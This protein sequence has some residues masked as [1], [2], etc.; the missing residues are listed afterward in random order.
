M[1]KKKTPMDWTGWV[2]YSPEV[3]SYFTSIQHAAHSLCRIRLNRRTVPI[4]A[5]LPAASSRCSHAVPLSTS[6]KRISPIS[7]NVWSGRSRMHNYA[8]I[9]SF[10]V[11][12]RFPFVLAPSSFPSLPLSWSV[13]LPLFTPYGDLLMANYWRT[14]L[15]A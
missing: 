11:P 14:F 4:V 7:A 5:S 10:I 12:Y 1:D 13:P 9:H 2:D 8:K 15:I 3:S 6:R